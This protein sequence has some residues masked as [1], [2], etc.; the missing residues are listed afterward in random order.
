[1]NDESAWEEAHDADT[2]A[3]FVGGAPP[4]SGETARVV[5]EL[6]WAMADALDAEYAAEIERDRT[7]SMAPAR[8]PDPEMPW[9]HGERERQLTLDLGDDDFF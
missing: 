3:L 8:W 5:V 1:M 6:L 2:R 9:R 7:G 4:L